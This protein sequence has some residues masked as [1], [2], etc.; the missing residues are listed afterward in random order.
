MSK[1]VEIE[2]IVFFQGDDYTELCK[3]LD[4]DYD[5]NGFV[6]VWINESD[7]IEY[8]L[9]WY[10]P[11]EHERNIYNAEYINTE[12]LGYERTVDNDTFLLSHNT[13]MGYAGLS[14][15]TRIFEE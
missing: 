3:S 6:A 7:L 2:N 5:P 1:K 8:I 13:R 14:R 15:I 11:N 10:Y 9:Q 12:F 4:S